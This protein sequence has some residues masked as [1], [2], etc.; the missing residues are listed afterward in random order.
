MSEIIV[1]QFNE[2]N[3]TLKEKRGTFLLVLCILTWINSGLGISGVASTLSKGEDLMSLQIE[4]IESTE[5]GN[6][7]FD[8]ILASSVET[9]VVTLENFQIYHIGSVLVFLVGILSAYLMFKLKKIGFFLYVLYCFGGLAF[10]YSIFGETSSAMLTMMLTGVM[11]IV[12]II[13][14]G[15]NLKRMTE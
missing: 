12:F 7:F 1:N 13:L 2:S 3:Q 15:V 14:Y 11:S 9:L 4:L 10:Y 6:E 8:K 5:S